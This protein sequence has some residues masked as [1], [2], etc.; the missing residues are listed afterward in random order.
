MIYVFFYSRFLVRAWAHEIT[1]KTSGLLVTNPMESMDSERGQ[2][3]TPNW[4]AFSIMALLQYLFTS[5]LENI[6]AIIS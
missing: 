3:V 6:R 1:R 2:Y 5:S 4:G